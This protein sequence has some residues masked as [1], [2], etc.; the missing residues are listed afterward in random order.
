[1]NKRDR[2]INLIR[3]LRSMTLTGFVLWMWR[4]VDEALGWGKE[5]VL[6]RAFAYLQVYLKGRSEVLSA[7]IVRLSGG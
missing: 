6:I 1:M 7:G 3:Y 2:L 5:R 4:V